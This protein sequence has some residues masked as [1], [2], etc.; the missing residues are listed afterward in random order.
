MPSILGADGVLL[1][2]ACTIGGGVDSATVT[3][4]TP[5]PRSSMP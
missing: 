2:T 4:A 5:S 1:G 3:G